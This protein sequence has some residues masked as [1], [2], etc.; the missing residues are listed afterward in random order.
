VDEVSS[1][2][3]NMIGKITLSLWITMASI[4][5]IAE[6]IPINARYI[7]PS[8]NE[9]TSVARSIIRV[10]DIIIVNGAPMALSIPLYVT[11]LATRSVSGIF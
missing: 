1:I 3:V 7:H 4:I 6:T 9:N 10:I 5:E 11:P 8:G 2:K